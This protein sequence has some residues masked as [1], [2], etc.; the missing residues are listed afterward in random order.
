LLTILGKSAIIFILIERETTERETNSRD[1]RPRRA[2]DS[3]ELE[4][5][6]LNFD[7]LR[8]GLAEKLK[9]E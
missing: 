6:S 5:N 3:T 1:S 4:T 2:T 7:H 9:R 8:E